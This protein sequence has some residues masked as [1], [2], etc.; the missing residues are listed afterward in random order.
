MASPL[1]RLNVAWLLPHAMA[2][3]SCASVI[4]EGD[5]AGVGKLVGL[6]VGKCEGAAVHSTRL[7]PAKLH[8]MA[9]VRQP[10]RLMQTGFCNTLRPAGE[11]TS[12]VTSDA[13][14]CKAPSSTKPESPASCSTICAMRREPCTVTQE[15]KRVDDTAQSHGVFKSDEHCNHAGPPA[16]LKKACHAARSLA[17]TGTLGDEVGADVGEREVGL[18]VVGERIADGNAVGKPVGRAVVG[19]AVVEGAWDVG[20]ADVGAADEGARE[21]GDA[22]EGMSVV[23]GNAVGKPVGRAVVGCAVVEGA[24]DVGAADVGA[25]EDGDA[26]EGACEVG[27]TDDG[28]VV[29]GEAVDAV[30]DLD[31]TAVHSASPVPARLQAMAPVRQPG[32]LKHA[33]FINELPDTSNTDKDSSVARAPSS[34]K[35]DSPLLR[36]TICAMRSVPCTSVQLT[37]TDDDAAH[38]HGV[39]ASDAHW[40]HAV[41]PAALKNACQTVTSLAST[42][43]V[44]DADVG[45][46]DEGE[47]D[48]GSCVT[49]RDD[50]RADG[51]ADG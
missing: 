5:S 26:D 19:C 10:E 38:W 23:D 31:G 3:V 16:A 30:G 34:A 12:N 28:A 35:P 50:G 36:S 13:S 46:K 24:W 40:V 41:P 51:R 22:D 15:T 32:R 11:D 25:R 29:T 1:F 6:R 49:G 42:G 4:D 9:P 20:A 47:R 37:N 8:A 18:A 2:T 43:I 45:D 17:S 27:A 7:V 33:G 39:F 21:D 14:D 44:G 48:V